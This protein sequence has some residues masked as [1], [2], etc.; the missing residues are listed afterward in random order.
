MRV[1]KNLLTWA[2]ASAGLLLSACSGSVGVSESEPGAGESVGTSQAELVVGS[3][4]ANVEPLRSIEIVHPSIV[5]DARSSNATDGVWSFR[6]QIENMAPSSAASDTDAFLRGIFES[7]Q[8]ENFVNGARQ[9]IRNSAA[10]MDRFTIAGSSPRQFNLANAPFKLI[11]VANRLDLRNNTQAGEG[12]LIYGLTNETDPNSAIMGPMTLIIEYA[13]PLVAPLDT[14]AKW[15]AKWHELDSIDPATAPATFASKLQEITDKFSVRGALPGRPNGS[16]VN[17]LR[18]NEIRFT[19]FNFWQL[20]E[21][22]MGSNGFMA[23]ATTKESPN[24]DF[25]NRSQEMRDF[26]N[27]N[28]VLNATSDTS[29]M[30]L[31]LPTT[32]EGTLFL[33][34]KQNQ[35]VGVVANGG[36]WDLSDTETEFTSV[37]I[38]NFGLLT[39]NGCHNEN[40]RGDDQSFYHVNPQ[41]DP[42]VDGTGRLS[43]FMTLGDPTKG[44]RRPAE[45]TRR[46][47][48]MAALLCAP[49]G[50][51][52]VV[53]K[54]GWAPA[55]ATPG[56]PIQFT[57]TVSNFG[58]TTKPAGII[59]GV[60]FRVDGNFVSWSDNN[61]AALAPGQSVTVTAN[62]G[63]F[64][65]AFWNTTAGAHSVEAWVDDVNRVAE[66]NENN[67]KTNAPLVAGIDL[68]VTN[69]MFSPTNSG[70]GQP[71]TFSATVK[72]EGNVATPAGTIIGV[73]FEVDGQLKTWSD[74]NT[75]SLAPGASRTLTANSGPQGVATWPNDGLI[76][77]ISAWVDDVARLNDVN[78]N[79]QKLTTRM[80]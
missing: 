39:C 37:P 1:G 47:N 61:T 48:D 23:P 71:I 44:G 74:T 5:N 14:P 29:F 55:N 4:N 41:V 64:N 20:R 67:N 43:K 9:D 22:N 60:A 12:R 2:G 70:I 35:Q 54:V 66:S 3:C 28:P 59:N 72:N 7:W 33:G 78:R 34:A 26:I 65:T 10:A 58:N 32:F 38:D 62:W 68:T 50:V 80:P 8:T 57:A 15:A 53:T 19:T 11:A 52:L 51:D 30:S 63:P 69:I 40:K 31:K 73:R 6:R 76:H 17:Q 77:R 13:L 46:A 75:Q 45:L 79:N 36:R 16:A 21:F 56:T 18:T 27:Q 49:S 25:L 24:W 42:G